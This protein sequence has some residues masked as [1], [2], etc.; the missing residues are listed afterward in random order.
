MASVGILSLQDEY[1]DTTSASSIEELLHIAI[2]T[3]QD[4]RRDIPSKFP[5]NVVL[6]ILGRV[7][8]LPTRKEVLDGV[9]G[10]GW[11][12]SLPTR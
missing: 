1:I 8:S 10:P 9:F 6:L 12:G 2:E 5:S 3:G 4:S 7:G 11:V